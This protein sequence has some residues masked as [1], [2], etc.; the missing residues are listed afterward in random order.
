VEV[1]VWQMANTIYASQINWRKFRRFSV[2]VGGIPRIWTA[3]N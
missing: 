1:K 3:R 2:F